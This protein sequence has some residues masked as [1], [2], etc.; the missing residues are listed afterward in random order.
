MSNEATDFLFAGGS[1][2]FSF[3]NI[4]DTVDGTIVTAE[5]RQQTDLETGT[6]LTWGDGTPRWQLVITLQTGEKI[7]DDDDGIR[8]IYAKGGRYEVAEGEGSSMKDAIA[9]AVRAAKAS[10]L[11]PGDRLAVALTGY[12]KKTN[13]AYNAPKL[14]TASFR[15]AEKSVSA[16]DLF[17]D[18]GSSDPF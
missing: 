7:N 1:R 3:D 2:A 5:K 18:D 4:N 15:K 8:A 6:P 16:K 14:Y 10:S 9:D 17:G 12:D 13:R 11:E